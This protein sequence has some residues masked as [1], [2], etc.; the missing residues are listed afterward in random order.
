MGALRRSRSDLTVDK[1]VEIRGNDRAVNTLRLFDSYR[2][3]PFNWL[4]ELVPDSGHYVGHRDLCTRMVCAGLLGRMTFD[5]RKNTN[6]TMTYWRTD[7]GDR[8]LHDKGYEGLPHDGTH[9]A[10]QVLTDLIDAQMQLG[11]RGTDTRFLNWQEIIRQPAFPPQGPQPFRFPIGTNPISK[12]TMHL[13]PD[14]RPFIISVPQPDGTNRSALFLKEL[15]R[16]NEEPQTIKGKIRNYLMCMDEI[17]KRYGRK[18]V[19]VLFVTT[20][21]TRLQNIIRWTLEVNSGPSQVFLFGFM[22]DH[23][24]TQRTTAP[25][26]AHLFNQPLERAGNRRYLLQTLSEI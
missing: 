3:L 12:K 5:G 19:M 25:V 16:N 8:F 7:A 9:D 18:Q 23:V 4:H 11:A 22:E 6:E 24:K 15:D 1:D 17:K 10:H 21:L 26:S 13:V 20:N 14:G 2:L